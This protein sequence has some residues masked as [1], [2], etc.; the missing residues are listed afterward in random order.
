MFLGRKGKKKKNPFQVVTK[1]L[2]QIHLSM[3]EEK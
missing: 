3:K 2:R 1:I